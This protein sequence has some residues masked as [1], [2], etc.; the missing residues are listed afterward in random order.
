MF[1]PLPFAAEEMTR[2]VV[3]DGLLYFG[4]VLHERSVDLLLDQP[5]RTVVWV[6]PSVELR[7]LA[8]HYSNKLMKM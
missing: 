4:Y 8:I 6:Q 2:R 3:V 5:I 1:T 7:V